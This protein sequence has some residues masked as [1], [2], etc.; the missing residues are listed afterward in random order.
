M[1]NREKSPNEPS[2][3]FTLA[4]S[5]EDS[6]IVVAS[7]LPDIGSWQH[8]DNKKS[9]IWWVMFVLSVGKRIASC[10]I[11]KVTALP[12]SANGHSTLYI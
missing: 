8:V 11:C 5:I 12:V 6:F 7:E 9:P 10:R 4:T 2:K 3:I 1:T